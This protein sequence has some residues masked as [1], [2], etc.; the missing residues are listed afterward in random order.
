MIQEVMKCDK[1]G[2]QSKDIC[3]DINWIRIKST[4]SIKFSVSG[5]RG[6][7]DDPKDTTHKSKVWKETKTDNIYLGDHA[8]DFCSVKC[9]LEWMGLNDK[10]T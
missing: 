4:S 2:K 3:G 9:M 7:K 8:I 6:K 10:E 1:C 5:G